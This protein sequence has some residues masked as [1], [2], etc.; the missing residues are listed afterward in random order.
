MSKVANCGYVSQ[1]AANVALRTKIETQPGY[2]YKL[3][4]KYAE[5]SYSNTAAHKNLVVRFGDEIIS[6]FNGATQLVEENIVVTA[7]NNFTRLVFFR[8]TGKPDTYGMIL[9]DIK[10]VNIGK[11][12]KYDDCANRFHV[13][14][15]G[16]AACLDGDED[17][18]DSCQFTEDQLKLKYSQ[19]T[20]VPYIRSNT[21]NLT[22]QSGNV[23]GDINFLSLGLGGKL[24]IKY[25]L[26][27]ENGKI[28]RGSM[29]IEGKSVQMEEITWTNN[30][31]SYPEEV[32]VKFKLEGCYEEALNKG[33]H[34][35]TVGSMTTNQKFKA[36]FGEEY[37]GCLLKK[38]V[39]KDLTSEGPSKDGADIN[40]FKI[41]DM[42]NQ[43]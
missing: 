7:K 43:L 18:L 15:A 16:F 33:L 30:P 17:S 8:D 29:A 3:S 11:D 13:G 2:K 41:T 36:D 5:R 39:L 25:A 37:K 22:N 20:G 23:R 38:I 19:G 40:G 12:D 26:S 9:D 42:E 10:I 1:E 28:K 14:S 34:T 35:H 24:V 21:A 4:F 6:K 32:S 27:N 31:A